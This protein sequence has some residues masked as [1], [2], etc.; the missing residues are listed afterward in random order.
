T[1][2]STVTTTRSDTSD[3]RPDC[4][5]HT[6]PTCQSPTLRRHVTSPPSSLAKCPNSRASAVSVKSSSAAHTS[7]TPKSVGV[8]APSSKLPSQVIV[9]L[10]GPPTPLTPAG[11]AGFGP[12]SDLDVYAPS[13]CRPTRPDK[14]PSAS[15]ILM[16]ES[17]K[18]DRSN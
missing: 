4:D 12:R 5:R 15:Y 1:T 10:A 16:Y 2:L 11:V 14:R 6:S 3:R 9:T 7:T 13:A 18:L 17:S 8:S